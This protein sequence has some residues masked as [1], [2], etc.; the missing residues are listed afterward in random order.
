MKYDRGDGLAEG[1]GGFLG[2]L[3]GLSH[4]GREPWCIRG[5]RRDQ[6]LETIRWSATRTGTI[7]GPAQTCVGLYALHSQPVHTSL[8][9][10]GG[11]SQMASYTTF[12]H[13]L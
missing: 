13:R 3:N 6:V 4:V 1:R 5:L 11:P 12:G 2:L 10:T 9:V 7:I 8:G